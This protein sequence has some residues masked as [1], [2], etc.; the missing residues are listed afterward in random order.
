MATTWTHT[1]INYTLT[2]TTPGYYS[3]QINVPGTA[4]P[5]D[6]VD[7][8]IQAFADYYNS[9]YPT[10]TVTKSY[11]GTGDSDWTYTPS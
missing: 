3:L 7:A 1:S 8:G 4:Q 11:D 5:E 10:V 6:D 2:S 9:K